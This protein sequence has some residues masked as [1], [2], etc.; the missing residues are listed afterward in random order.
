[1]SIRI[2]GLL[3]ALGSVFFAANSVLGSVQF[4]TTP[5]ASSFLVPTGVTSVNVLAIGGGGGGANGHQGGGGSGYVSIGTFSVNPGD[6]IPI[7]VGSGG[8]GADSFDG[9]NVIFGLTPGT[10]SSF[11]AFLSAAG[12]GV[13]TDVN[14]GGNNGGSGGGAGG[15]PGPGGAGGTGGGNGGATS[16]YMG[17]GTG[18]GSYIASLSL[19]IENVLTAGLGGAG[20][21]LGTHNGGGGGGGILINGLGPVAQ[22]GVQPWSGQGGS[23]YGAGGGAGGLDQFINEVRYAGGDGASGLVY[24]EYVG[25]AAAVPEPATLIV[26]GTIVGLTCVNAYRRR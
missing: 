9:D 5:G 25:L 11:G 1:M 13:V 21:T 24:I 20:G 2:S 4:F 16:F 10:S 8:S 12:G 26:W 14:E 18:Q 22:S 17:F 3:A 23:G 7:T 6:T 19:F 15:N